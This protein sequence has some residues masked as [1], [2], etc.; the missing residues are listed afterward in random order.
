MVRYHRKHCELLGIASPGLTSALP[1]AKELV[2]ELSKL[3]LGQGRRLEVKNQ[4]HPDRKPYIGS[5]RDKT[6]VSG[7]QIKAYTSLPLEDPECLVCRCE[8]VKSRVIEEAVRRNKTLPFRSVAQNLDFLKWR[9]RV[10]MGFCQGQFCKPRL[11]RLLAQLTG[12]EEISEIQGRNW[13]RIAPERL[14]HEL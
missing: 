9:T 10:T 7:L 11:K 12:Q 4:F 13:E 6:F 5:Q 3:W 14:R 8:Q 2:Q 1:I